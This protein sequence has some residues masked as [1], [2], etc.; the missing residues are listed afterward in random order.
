MIYRSFDS[1]NARS[2]DNV[3][4]GRQDDPNIGEGQFVKPAIAAPMRVAFSTLM[5]S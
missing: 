1:L 5:I 2:P 4:E 3:I